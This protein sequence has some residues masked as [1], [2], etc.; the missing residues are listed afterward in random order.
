MDLN[1]VSNNKSFKKNTEIIVSEMK[2]LLEKIDNLEI[3][4]NEN[5]KNMSDKIELYKI[6]VEN[7]LLEYHQVCKKIIK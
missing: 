1:L 4:L 3:E 7:M 5:N 2:G 6:M